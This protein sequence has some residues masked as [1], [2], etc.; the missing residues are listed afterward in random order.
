MNPNEEFNTSDSFGRGGSGEIGVAALDGYLYLFDFLGFG[1]GLFRLRS[2]SYERYEFRRC[3]VGSR[4]SGYEHGRHRVQRRAHAGQGD[5]GSGR[6]DLEAGPGRGSFFRPYGSQAMDGFSL[7][8]IVL[9]L[10]VFI[11]MVLPI[12]WRF[13]K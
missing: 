8:D 1:Y 7:G 5:G 4:W 6:F 11:Q 3:G 9:F 10:G 12:L 13:L 2:L